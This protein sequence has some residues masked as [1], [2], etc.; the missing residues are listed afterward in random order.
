MI[1]RVDH[2][3]QFVNLVFRDW[4]VNYVDFRLFGGLSRTEEALEAFVLLSL[5]SDFVV[6]ALQLVF[7]LSFKSFVWN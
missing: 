5:G 4:L 7:M 6:E 3:L 1:N 2:L